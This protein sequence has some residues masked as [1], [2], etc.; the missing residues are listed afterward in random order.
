MKYTLIG[1]DRII[2]QPVALSVAD[3]DAII[4]SFI[5]NHVKVCACH[6]N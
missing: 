5:T 4:A 3:T 2:E 6:Q 1:C